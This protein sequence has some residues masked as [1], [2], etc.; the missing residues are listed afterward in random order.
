MNGRLFEIIPTGDP[1]NKS[2]WD[3]R[4]YAGSFDEPTC[5]FRGDLSPVQGKGNAVTTLRRL[6]PGC[7]VRV[8]D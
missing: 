4:E 3:V 7:V 8:S 6:Y 1:Y 2:G 5:T